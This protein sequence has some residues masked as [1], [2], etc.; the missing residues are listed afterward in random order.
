MW[1]RSLGGDEVAG[2]AAG[3]VKLSLA[4]EPERSKLLGGASS[5]QKSQSGRIFRCNY[6]L[7]RIELVSDGTLQQRFPSANIRIIGEPPLKLLFSS[8]ND[9]GTASDASIYI[10]GPA[11]PLCIGSCG[12]GHR[13][14]V[15]ENRQGVLLPETILDYADRVPINGGRF[16]RSLALW[17]GHPAASFAPVVVRDNDLAQARLADRVSAA[18]EPVGALGGSD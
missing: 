6:R 7:F 8:N 18:V 5:L 15:Y 11:A 3:R 9:D 16:S 13:K 4:D 10:D 1:Q 14:G 17:I 2:S 12:S